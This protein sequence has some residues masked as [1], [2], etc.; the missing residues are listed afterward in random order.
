MWFAFYST[1][2]V[3]SLIAS[4][5]YSIHARRKGVHPLESRMI[6]GKMNI[7]LGC[8]LILFGSNQF[9]FADLD[10][11]RIIVAIVMLLVGCVNL[12]LGLKNFFSY[13]REWASYRSSMETKK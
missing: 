2:L 4:V 6:L 12:V 1:G 7:A 9:T 5:Y 8:L 3:V 13:R 10:T 11:I